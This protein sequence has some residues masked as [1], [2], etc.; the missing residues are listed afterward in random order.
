MGWIS[1]MKDKG[2]HIVRKTR[3]EKKRECEIGFNLMVS[4]LVFLKCFS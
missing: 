2:H 1:Q 4:S 3:R